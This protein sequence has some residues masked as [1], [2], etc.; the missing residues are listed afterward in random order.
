MTEWLRNIQ[1]IIGDIDDCIRRRDSDDMTLGF[2]A[3]KLGYTPTYTSRK[4]H[5]VSGMQFRDYLRARRLAFALRDLRDSQMGIL[6]IALNYGYSSHEAFT[7]ALRSF[8]ASLLRSTAR[9]PGL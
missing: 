4:F 9:S 5:Q 1:N 8:T 3:G 2:I 7:R 6:E